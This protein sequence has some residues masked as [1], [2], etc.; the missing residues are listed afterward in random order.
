MGFIWDLSGMVRILWSLTKIWTIPKFF[1]IIPN[2]RLMGFGLRSCYLFP[3]GLV[4]WNAPVLVGVRVKFQRCQRC[5]SMSIFMVCPVDP[6]LLGSLCLLSFPTDAVQ[7]GVWASV[8]K[9]K[10]TRS[11]FLAARC[12]FFDL[13]HTV[14]L[15]VVS[16]TGRKPMFGVPL[17]KFDC[18]VDR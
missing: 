14:W 17:P 4:S 13:K 7:V 3:L 5:L 8:H 2:S 12:P 9:E 1:G 11:L 18:C 15:L 6:K 10:T 16:F